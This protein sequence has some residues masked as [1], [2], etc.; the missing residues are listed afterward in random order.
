MLRRTRG[1]V[2]APGSRSARA[3]LALALALVA[4]PGCYWRQY[5]RLMETHLS[6]LLEYADKL[7]GLAQDHRVVPPERWGEFTYPLERARDFA[8]IARKR[9]PDRASL[10]SFDVAVERYAAL[11]A[12]PRVLE[13]ADAAANVAAQLASLRQAADAARQ[14]LDREQRGAPVG[15]SAGRAP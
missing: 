10:T 3:A 11:V 4:L 9:F 8:R 7:L 13:P 15:E 5:P 6:L 2:K 14:A 1:P 12:D